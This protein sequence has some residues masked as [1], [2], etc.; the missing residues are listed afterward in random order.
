MVASEH[1]FGDSILHIKKFDKDGN[2]QL[3]QHIFEI[4]N[5]L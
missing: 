2:C 5:D 1:L 4:K 3:V